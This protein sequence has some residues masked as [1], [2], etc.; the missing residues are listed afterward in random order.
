M[1]YVLSRSS[2]TPKIVKALPVLQTPGVQGCIVACE[3]TWHEMDMK[4]MIEIRAIIEAITK[5]HKKALKAAGLNSLV[6]AYAIN[7]YGAFLEEL[8]EMLSKPV[9]IDVI[10]DITHE[11]AAVYK[12]NRI[13]IDAIVKCYLANCNAAGIAFIRHVF[14]CS[15]ALMQIFGDETIKKNMTIL[16]KLAVENGLQAIEALR[17]I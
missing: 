17:N 2:K 1:K 9:A 4:N 10:R 13:N 15:V 12:D 3:K 11:L 8:S 16:H 6:L 5:K 14:A 7:N